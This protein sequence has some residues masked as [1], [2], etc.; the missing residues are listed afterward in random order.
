MIAALALLSWLLDYVAGVMGAKKVGAS[1]Q[2]LVGAAIGTVAGLFMGLIGV[3]VLPF[4]GAAIGEYVARR[5]HQAAARVGLATGI[6]L[7][8]AFFFWAFR[9]LRS[10]EQAG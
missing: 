9:G 4:V 3:F 6:G 2:A 10:A 8:V 1:P 5:D 7:V